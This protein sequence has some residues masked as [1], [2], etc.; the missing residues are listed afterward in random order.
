MVLIIMENGELMQRMDMVF[1]KI[2]LQ[3]IYMQDLGN[4]T[5][6]MD[7]EERPPQQ[8]YMKETLLEIKSKDLVF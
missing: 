3:D 2:S 7:M 6:K 5:K 8:L 1:I 4:K